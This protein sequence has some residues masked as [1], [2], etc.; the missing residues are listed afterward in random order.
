MPKENKSVKI[1]RMCSLQTFKVG[2]SQG[3][4]IIKRRLPENKTKRKMFQN[5][6]SVTFG[7]LSSQLY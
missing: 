3:K 4:P 7:G 6:F 2:L 5:G 1:L